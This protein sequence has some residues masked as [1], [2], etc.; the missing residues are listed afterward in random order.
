[1]TRPQLPSYMVAELGDLRVSLRAL[2]QSRGLTVNEVQ[3]VVDMVP[4]S[5]L[6]SPCFRCAVKGLWRYEFGEPFDRLPN[7]QIVVGAHMFI[8]VER[9]SNALLCAR[10]R[11][12]ED[13]RNAWLERLADPQKHLDVLAEMLPVARLPD[14]VQAEFEVAGLGSGNRT[15]D[16]VITLAAGPRIGSMPHAT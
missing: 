2:G 10:K 4:P 9:L 6:A 13:K 11:L 14:A 8:P 1:M 12:S 15:L 5:V 3:A 16:W 7:G